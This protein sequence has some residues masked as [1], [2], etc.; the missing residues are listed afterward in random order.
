MSVATLASSVDAS[1]SA[2]SLGSGALVLTCSGVCVALQHRRQAFSRAF[3]RASSHTHTGHASQGLGA[4]APVLQH[5]AGRLHKVML[6]AEPRERHG[7]GGGAN[8]VHAEVNMHNVSGVTTG[9]AAFIARSNLH[10]ACL[11]ALADSSRSSNTVAHNIHQQVSNT[12]CTTNSNPTHT[13]FV[14]AA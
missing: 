6:T 8:V 3:V 14:E 5:L 11:A 12:V 2:T 1:L 10:M 9:D 7:L 13:K 4:P